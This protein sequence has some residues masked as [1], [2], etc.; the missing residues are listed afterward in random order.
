MKN[1]TIIDSYLVKVH[2]VVNYLKANNIEITNSMLFSTTS[3][4]DLFKTHEA[5]TAET[6]EAEQRKTNNDGKSFFE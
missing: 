1:D 5:E 3:I 2:K 4:C 6:K